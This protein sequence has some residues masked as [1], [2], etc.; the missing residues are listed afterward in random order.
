M[1]TGTGTQVRGIC[2]KDH[3]DPEILRDKPPPFP[4]DRR[5]FGWIM[6]NWIRKDRAVSRWDENTVSI[7]VE[8]LMGTGK[9]EFASQLADMLGMRY[10]GMP[11]VEPLVKPDNG[12]DYRT[13]NWLLPEAAQYCDQKLFYLNP[14]HGAVG[15]FLTDMFFMKYFHQLE[16]L[17][18]IF[19]TGQGVVHEGS[20]WSDHIFH[21]ALAQMGIV[22]KDLVEHHYDLMMDMQQQIHRPHVVI[23]LDMPAEE[24]RRRFLAKAPDH[25]KNSPLMYNTEYFDKLADLYKNKFLPEI[26]KHAEVLI[27]DWTEGGDM[28]MVV[29]DLE[30]LDMIRHDCMTEKLEDW[31]H[32]K[33]EDYDKDRLRFTAY[34]WTIW[35][36]IHQPTYDKPSCI[37]SEEAAHFR[38]NIVYQYVST[39]HI[40]SSIFHF[41]LP[42]LF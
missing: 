12:F 22:Q 37:M 2:H 19:N 21:Q 6:K 35:N 39:F 34:R 20:L 9:H 30:S 24:A 3:I 4:Y 1:T 14:Q 27:Y 10:Y 41:C 13:L 38:D 5:K 40:L 33:D 17:T 26:T 36:K 8:G 23:Y 16:G 18:H 15:S 42:A 28:D 31:R 25:I 7:T 29:E 32:Y 11:D